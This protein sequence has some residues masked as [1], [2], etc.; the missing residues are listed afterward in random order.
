MRTAANGPEAL[1]VALAFKPQIALLDIGLPVMDGYELARR[2]RESQDE[3]GLRL[4][5]VTGYGQKSDK[6]RARAGGFDAHLVKPVGLEQLEAVL[7]PGAARNPATI[8][9]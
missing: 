4:I 7:R 8:A 9:R 5:A 1:Q 3:P 2:L 6:R